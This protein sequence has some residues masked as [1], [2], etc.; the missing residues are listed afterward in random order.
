MAEPMVPEAPSTRALY[1]G[2][3]LRMSISFRRKSGF[4]EHH[5]GVAPH[6]LSNACQQCQLECIKLF[7]IVPGGL[8]NR[9]LLRRRQCIP[10][11][12]GQGHSRIVSKS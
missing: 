12:V 5:G 3:K 7:Q 11:A 9:F 8:L 10:C 1:A 6:Y 4:F 2:G